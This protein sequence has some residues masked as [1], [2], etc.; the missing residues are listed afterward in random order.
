MGVAAK[1]NIEKRRVGCILVNEAGEIIGEGFNDE[2]KHAEI[3]AINS[4]RGFIQNVKAYVT[5]QPCPECARALLRAGVTEVEVVEQFLKFDGDKL[6]LDLIPVS[7]IIALGEVL[8]FGA[9][10]YKPNNWKECK[11][12]SRYEAA[13]LRH[14]YAYKAGEKIDKDSGKPHLWHALANLAFLVELDN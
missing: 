12:L 4:T 10:K 13:L 3:N 8:T 14:F 5:H 11:D 2:E 9:R 1:S 6:R 7:T